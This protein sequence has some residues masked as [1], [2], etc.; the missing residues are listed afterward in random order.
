[1]TSD[2]LNLQTVSSMLLQGC[3]LLPYDSLESLPKKPKTEN[4]STWTQSKS[5]TPWTRGQL[6]A[7]PRLHSMHSWS[8][9]FRR[10]HCKLFF[11][12]SLHALL[13]TVNEKIVDH[14]TRGV[15]GWSFAEVK[16]SATVSDPSLWCVLHCWAGST[17]CHQSASLTL[18]N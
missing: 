2:T 1:M 14:R 9:S 3:A 7:L 5:C 16:Q 4:S 8:I 6:N 15:S 10:N 18:L 11:V 12:K 13:L 17:F